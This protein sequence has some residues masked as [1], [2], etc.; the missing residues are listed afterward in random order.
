M[1][2]HDTKE[3]KAKVKFRFFDFELEGSNAAL[4][5]TVRTMAQTLA[6]R[7]GNGNAKAL[8]SAVATA[9]PNGQAVDANDADVDVLEEIDGS[10]EAAPRP[11]SRARTSKA[12]VERPEFL[13]DLVK[14]ADLSLAD[15]VAGHD[16]GQTDYSRCAAIAKWLKDHVNT[17][18]VTIDH[19]FTGYRLMN[20]PSPKRY[21][22]P[23]GDMTDKKNWLRRAGPGKYQITFIGEEAVPKREQA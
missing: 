18:T 22:N 21:R 16:V 19:F 23:L 20:W 11:T 8:A 13:D 7:D 15:F 10:V 3:D 6:R 4:E 9:L 5:A 14:T 12:A 17:D 2:K 1:A